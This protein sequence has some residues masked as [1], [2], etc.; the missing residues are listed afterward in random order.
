MPPCINIIFPLQMFYKMTRIL[1]KS[2]AAQ[3]KQY[4]YQNIKNK[5]NSVDLTGC[6]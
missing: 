2:N 4:I 6:D 5:D 1:Y 3:G